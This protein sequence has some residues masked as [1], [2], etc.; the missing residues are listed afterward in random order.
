MSPLYEFKCTECGTEFEA[1]RAME[2]RD[3]FTPCPKCHSGKLQ[4]QITAPN[5]T[6]LPTRGPQSSYIEPGQRVDI[7][8]LVD[9]MKGKRRGKKGT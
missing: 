2:D 5:L 1:V 9:E 3:R 8:P 4:R 6:G 7:P